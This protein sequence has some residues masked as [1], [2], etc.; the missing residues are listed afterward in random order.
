MKQAFHDKND[1]PK[2]AINQV[3]EHV[4]AKYQA[5]THSNNLPMNILEQP[6]ASGK[7]KSYL[8]LLHYPGQKG[9]FALTS[10][11]K[12]LK[13]VLPNNFNTQIAIIVVII[14]IIIII[15]SLF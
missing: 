11:K 6:S 2:W 5:V 7:E 3:S 14:I 4:E 12:K 13:T 8:L 10:V 9:Y 15:N 1:Y